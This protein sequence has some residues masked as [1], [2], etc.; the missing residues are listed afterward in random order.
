M[1]IWTPRIGDVGLVMFH[2]LR[3]R[4]G[5]SRKNRLDLYTIPYYIEA[6][7]DASGGGAEKYSVGLR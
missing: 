1:V 3:P 6:C 4:I 5:S 7:P 2:E